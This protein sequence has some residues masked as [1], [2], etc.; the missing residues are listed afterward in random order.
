MYQTHP[1]HRQANVSR[2]SQ[3][4]PNQA[5]FIFGDETEIVSTSQLGDHH[6]PRRYLFPPDGHHRIDRVGVATRQTLD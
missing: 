2:S 3:D 5:T 6:F 4:E 1:N